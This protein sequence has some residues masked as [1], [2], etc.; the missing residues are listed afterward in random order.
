MWA[1]RFLKF[2]N[3]TL[4]AYIII[5]IIIIIIIIIIIKYFSKRNLLYECLLTEQCE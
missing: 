4:F 2:S 3:Y 5:V 1:F